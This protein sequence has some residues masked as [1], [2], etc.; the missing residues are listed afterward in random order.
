[1]TVTSVG[2]TYSPQDGSMTRGSSYSSG[3]GF[4]SASIGALAAGPVGALAGAALDYGLNSISANSANKKAKKNAMTQFWMQNYFMDKQNEYN[5]PINQMKRLE[6]AGLN[7]NL[8]YDNGTA[9]IA[10]ASASGGADAEVFKNTSELGYAASLQQAMALARADAE[11]RNINANTQR[12]ITQTDMDVGNYELNQAILRARDY[13]LR[14]QGY[15]TQ[16]D[17]RFYDMLNNLTGES[18]GAGTNATLKLIG[19]LAQ[20][21]SR[22]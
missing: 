6:E 16:L 19:T 5:K 11:I 21:L 13:S 3:S 4:S 22:R 10:S 20:I 14:Q 12:T 1:M 18:G 17:N 9:T 8:V 15:R 2:G 7:K